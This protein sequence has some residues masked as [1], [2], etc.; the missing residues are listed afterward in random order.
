[1]TKHKPKPAESRPAR[2]TDDAERSAREASQLLG[3]GDDPSR[4][5]PAD[6]LRCDLVA[7]LRIAIDHAGATAME[8][9]STDVGRLVSAVEQLTKLLPAA[10]T[11]APSHRAD[12]RKAL[13]ALIMQQRERDGIPDEGTTQATINAQAAEIAQLRAQLAGKTPED[14]D[15]PTVVERVPAP[16]PAAKVVPLPRAAAP[17]PAAKASPSYDYD[18]ERGWRDHVQPD[19]SISPTPFGGG[20]KWWGPV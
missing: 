6:R 19:G 10:A 20:R 2:H 16:A 4:L 3:L 8:G 7:T 17:G 9:G 11:A 5:C 12:P 1:M 14:S 18:R 15:V 13:L